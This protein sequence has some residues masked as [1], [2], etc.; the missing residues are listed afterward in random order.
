[1]LAKAYVL[2]DQVRALPCENCR[3]TSEVLR[4]NF[5]NPNLS[6]YACKDVKCKHRL[7]RLDFAQKAIEKIGNS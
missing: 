7:L 5:G 2:N 6:L 4:I 3:S 1:M